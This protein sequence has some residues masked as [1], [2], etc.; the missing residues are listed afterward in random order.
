MKL[1]GILRA[2]S[3]AIFWVAIGLFVYWFFDLNCKIP[4]V[5]IMSGVTPLLAFFAR[6]PK[7][8]GFSFLFHFLTLALPGIFAVT[9]L[10]DLPL[11][12]FGMGIV[13][14]SYIAKLAQSKIL[15]RGNGFGCVVLVLIYLIG[16]V[17]DYN[18]IWAH[19]GIMVVYMILVF[20]E[21]NIQKAEDY[22]EKSSYHSV[23]DIKKL[24]G[25]SYTVIL[26]I[27]VATLV[28]CLIFAFI[29]KIE[30]LALLS[31]FFHSK[32][33][34]LFKFLKRLKYR[35]DGVQNDID[36][37]TPANPFEGEQMPEGSLEP[38]VEIT[39]ND[40]VCTAFMLS[41]FLTCLLYIIYVFLK[42]MYQKYL[43]YKTEGINEE[44]IDIKKKNR[45]KDNPAKD[46][47]SYSNRMTIRKIYKKRIKGKRNGRREDF[48]NCTPMEQRVKSNLDGNEISTEMI[49]LYEKARYSKEEI[50]KNDVKNMNKI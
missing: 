32:W 8:V 31:A 19:F 45:V 50:T 41:L 23:V 28:I 13:V 21:V 25:I 22:I 11:M 48:N 14:I 16:S 15:D 35:D 33:K 26:I 20:T 29:G 30:P 42:K 34:Q 40:I 44:H 37:E 18:M 36:K 3:I 10:I 7:N 5:I 17:M 27:A 43:Q 1:S 12:F 9:E 24:S 47:R 6:V 2:V 38:E 46:D 49:D 4:I 39:N